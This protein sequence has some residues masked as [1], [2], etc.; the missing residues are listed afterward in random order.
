[1]GGTVLIK[2]AELL[3]HEEKNIK[4]RQSAFFQVR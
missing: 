1:M 3:K 2:G 4:L